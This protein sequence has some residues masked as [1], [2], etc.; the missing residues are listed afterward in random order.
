MAI[1]LAGVAIAAGFGAARSWGL[2]YALRAITNRV[3]IATVAG[4]AGAIAQSMNDGAR[5][6]NVDENSYEE[7]INEAKEILQENFNANSSESR[8][9]AEASVAQLLDPELRWPRFQNGPR[10]GELM[11]PN[12]I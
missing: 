10:A 11:T 5:F 9:M 1:P 6:G 12:Y 4:T 3:G 7:A 2:K 8:N